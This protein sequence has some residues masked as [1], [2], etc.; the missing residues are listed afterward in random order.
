MTM[1]ERVAAMLQQQMSKVSS[2]TR[3]YDDI[4]RKVIEAMREPTELMFM[5]GG[6]AEPYN[7]DQTG[8]MLGRR[9]GDK[10]ARDAW[11]IMIETALTR[12]D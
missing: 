9:I 10:P 2:G 11:R 7:R 8:R 12:H 1:V 6:D 3:T 5:R 4:A